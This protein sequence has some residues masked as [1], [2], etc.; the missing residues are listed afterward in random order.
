MVRS[1]CLQKAPYGSCIARPERSLTPAAAHP[2]GGYARPVLMKQPPNGGGLAFRK[3]QQGKCG[4]HQPAPIT[5]REANAAIFVPRRSLTVPIQRLCRSRSRAT[6]RSAEHAPE[7]EVL[8]VRHQLNVLRR[9]RPG[10]PRLSR[11][12]PYSAQITDRV[13]FGAS[14]GSVNSSTDC[15]VG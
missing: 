13:R 12:C 6:K 5:Q 8:A 15:A 9:Q 11:W 14:S 2:Q 1:A 4:A 3:P 10:R 7:L